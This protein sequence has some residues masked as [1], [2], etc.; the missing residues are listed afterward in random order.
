MKPFFWI[1]LSVP[2]IL[3][4]GLF[5]AGERLESDASRA[6]YMFLAF[7]FIIGD[8]LAFGVLV[9]AWRLYKK[10]HRGETHPENFTRNYR[11]HLAFGIGLLFPLIALL[12]LIWTI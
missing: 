2:V 12:V 4:I 9:N 7:A 6:L 1:V 8:A 5:I 10:E 11:L 3:L